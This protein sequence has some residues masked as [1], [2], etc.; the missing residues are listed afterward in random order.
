MNTKTKTNKILASSMLVILA[1]VMVFGIFIANPMEASAATN[2]AGVYMLS[3]TYDIGDGSVSGYMDQFG[4]QIATEVFYDDSGYNSTTKYNYEVYDWTYFSFYIHADDIKEHQSFKLTKDGSTYVNLTLSGDTG[5]YLWKGSL[6]TGY[7]VLTYVGTYKPNIFST[8]TYT[9]TYRFYVDKDKPTYSLKAGGSTISSGSYTNKAI[10]YSISDYSS[11]KLYY[12]SPGSSSYTYTTSTSKSVSATSANNGWWYFYGTDGYQSSSTVSVYLDTVAPVGKVTNSSGTTISNGGYTNKPVKYTATDTGGVSYCQV[13]NPGS[14]TWSTYTA[15]TALS[16]SHGWYTFRSVDKAGNTSSEYKV[17][18]DSTAPT[19]TL[20]GGTTTKS[21]GGYTNAS[22]VKYVASD[23]HSGVKAC[24]V[25]KPG[26]TSYVAYT[27]GTQLTAEGTYYFYCVDNSGNQS[28][29]VSIT[30][31]KTVPTGTLYGGTSTKSSGSYTNASYVKYTAS[32]SLSGVNACYVKMPGASSYTSYSSGTQLATQGTYYFYCVDKAGNSSSVVSITLDTTKPTGTLYGGT[33]SISSG[34]HTK[35]SYVKYV[36]SDNIALNAIYVKKP[37]SSSYVAYTSGTQ[38]T[39]QGVYSFYCTDKAG[40]TSATVTVTLDRTAPV[41]TVYGGTTSKTSGSYTNASYVKYTATDSLSSAI[42][43]YVKMPGATSYTTYASGTQLATEGTYSFYS[44]DKAGNQSSVSTITLDVTKPTGKLYG[45]ST[46]LSS[47]DSTNASSVKFVPSDNIALNTIFVKAPGATSYAAYTSGKELTAEGVYS[48]YAVDKAGNQSAT[49]T[50]TVNRQ[51][52]SAQL[53]VDDKAVGNGTY[54]NGDYIKFVCGETCY[55]KAP[56]S[57]SFTAYTSGAELNKSGKYVFYGEDEAGN[58]TGEYT[59]VIDR[60]IKKVNISNVTNGTTDGDAV[61]TWT[62]GDANTY[63][64]IT[65]VKVNGKAITNGATVHTI[66]TGTYK[67]TVLD[68]AGN[69][70]ET[71]FTSTKDNIPT[72]TLQKEYYEVHDANGD[73]F[74]FDSYESALEFA[75]KRENSLVRKGTWSSISWDTGIAMDEK[76]SVNAVNGEYFIYKKSGNADE[77]VAYFTTERLDEVIAEYAK[78]GIKSYYYWQKEPAVIA[79]G[80]NLYSYSDGTT[81]L[82]NSIELGADI[83]VLIDGEVYVGASIETE[84]KHVIT[85]FDDFGNTREYTMIVVRKAPAIQYTVGEGSTNTATFER[86]YLFKDEV[87]LSIIDEIDEFAMFRVYDEDGELLAILNADETFKVTESGSYTVIAVN[88]AGD[89]ETFSFKI[90]RNA[91]SVSLVEDAEEKQLVITINKSEDDESHIQSI[92]IQKSTDNGETWVTLTEDDYG[93][94]I[95]LDTLAYKFRT[96]GMYK[97]VITDEFRTGIDAISGQIT[98]EQPIP[99]GDLAGVQDGGITNTDVVFTWDDEAVV[100]V[101]K[102]GEVIPYESGDKLTADGDYTITFENFDGHKK[103][104]AFTIDTEEPEVEMEGADHRESVNT[105]VKVFYTE[106]NLKAE[107]F[108]DGKSLGEYVSGNPISADGQYRVRV[109][110]T[111]GN[112]V[113]V[114]FTIDKTVSYDINV[115]DKGLSNSVV[116]TAK[117]QVTVVLTKNGEVVDYKLGSEITEPADYVLEL[118]DALN[119]RAQI[120]FKVIQPYVTEFTHN[121]DDIEGMGGVTVNGEDHR[122]NYGTLELKTDGVYEVGVTVSG[123][124]YTFKV[125]VDTKVGFSINAHDKGLA[126]SVTINA[127]EDVTVTVTKNGE[128]IN[129]VVGTEITEPAAYTVKVE[130]K[131]GNKSEMSFT[132]IVSTVNKFESEVDLVPGFEKVL[133]NGKEATL[134]RGT[135]TLTE[136]GTYDVAIVAN[137]VTQSFK[138]TI[139]ADVA[140]VSSVHD[141]G[142]ANTA[143]LTANE[144]VTVVVT[145]NGEPFEYKLGD[146]IVESGVYTAKF[147]DKLGNTSEVTFTIVD[148]LVG[149]FESDIASIPGFEKVIVNDTELD[150]ENAIL[151]LTESGTYK[152]EVV[153]NGVSNTFEITVDAT[154]PTLTV[155]GVDGEGRAKK[156]VTLTDLSEEA[157]VKVFLNDTEIEYADGDELTEEGTYKVVVT[158]DCGNSTEYNFEIKHGLNGGIIA[159]IVI[160]SLLAVGGV[161]VFIL[162]KKTDVF[163][164]KR[165]R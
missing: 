35:A 96:S 9:F 120:A 103:V 3:G 63:A 22:Y 43:Y 23:S 137:G 20:Y 1:L 16:A 60:T 87:T 33:S 126:N 165:Y 50:V 109:V 17:Y 118:T 74:A 149:K 56:G 162:Y 97:V 41:G 142:Y 18:Y 53:Y 82:A 46:L 81:I 45:G 80:E 61:I 94:T 38:L 48:F 24:Y 153:A 47:G 19:G 116:A 107:L 106:E 129:Y 37:G 86:T 110:D 34:T 77:E 6:P 117:E 39:D 67:V 143:K 145:K 93:N 101:E 135:L 112:E 69:T 121:F 139:D 90:S 42:T 78:V 62:N 54:T 108:K 44:V 57:T 122:L 95:V 161:V 31:D 134:D 10:S 89:S 160:L 28:T 98:Y 127:T 79:D 114:E 91:P 36:P 30:L 113:S 157:T 111:A 68:A 115:Y 144:D 51:I 158:D 102:N 12:K 21:S 132:I 26:S 25:K 100:T 83:G 136:S 58:S 84:G 119:N 99:A 13:K 141:K 152:V 128:A 156:T 59:I 40:N 70:W 105:D 88:H 130:D 75:I 49:Y 125:T 11:T 147:T 65:S 2:R 133:V 154:A 131:L 29:T 7:Y 55:V 123:K 164:N 138:V 71:E 27:S 4:I 146:D 72:V 14:S 159:L 151:S 66:E 5:M 85:V 124:V 104:Y 73:I 8:K 148:A 64:P 92:V 163:G 140:F 15:G 76:D 155:N 150:M 32:D 52:P